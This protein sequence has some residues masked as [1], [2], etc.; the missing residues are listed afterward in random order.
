MEDAYDEIEL[1]GFPLCDSFLLA[2][3]NRE[4]LVYARDLKNFKNKHVVLLGKLVTVKDVKTVKG[5]IMSFGTFLDENGDWLDTVHF[6]GS[7]NKFP[8]QGGGFY[9]IQG[10]VVE[11]FAVCSVEV[12][13]LKLVGLKTPRITLPINPFEN[14]GDQ[15]FLF[16]LP[17]T[18]P[19]LFRGY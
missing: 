2:G 8:F 13:A 3:D 4:G 5:E 15:L 9:R 17:P 6:P 7:R 16:N 1:L 14:I 11:E 19:A 10:K 12:T 18:L